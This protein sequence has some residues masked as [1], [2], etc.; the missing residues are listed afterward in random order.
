MRRY[1]SLAPLFALA[2][3]LAPAVVAAAPHSGP[4]A[5]CGP[6]DFGAPGWPACITGSAPSDSP[7]NVLPPGIFPGLDAPRAPV[8]PTSPTGPAP[9]RSNP[10]DQIPDLSTLPPG[11]TVDV[12]RGNAT[13]WGGSV[14]CTATNGNAPGCTSSGDL[15]CATPQPGT[16]ICQGGN[17]DG[18]DAAIPSP[19]TAAPPTAAPSPTMSMPMPTEAP[20]DLPSTTTTVPTDQPTAAPPASTS[21]PVGVSSDAQHMLDLYNSRRTAAG[22]QPVALNDALMRSAQGYADLLNSQR[23]S[24]PNNDPRWHTLAGTTAKQRIQQAGCPHPTTW[25]EN[26]AVGT[27]DQGFTFWYGEGPG[28]GHYENIM[29]PAYTQI[30]VGIAGRYIVVDHA[31]GCPTSTTAAPPL[32]ARPQPTRSMPMPS[33]TTAPAPIATTSSG[34]GAPEST[35]LLAAVNQERQ[36]A[37]LQP[38]ALADPLQASAQGYAQTMAANEPK[39]LASDTDATWHG[40]DGTQPDQRV[41]SA[42]CRWTS[43]GENV[44]GGYPTVAAVM[45]GWMSSPGHKAN[46]LNPDYRFVGFGHTHQQGGTMHDFWVQDFANQC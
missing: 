39:L 30:G 3:L 6:L 31:A 44:A 24:F 9:G 37:G 42:G 11:S 28:G 35:A 36:K 38:L 43:T 18:G 45:A 16:I 15:P 7:S 32:T 17:T 25:G 27:V 10:W 21:A 33:A 8:L 20:V 1:L 12:G 26:I 46:I 40:V 5:A 19:P 13:S 23:A 14:S 2:V 4:A 34:T 22:R 41:S 29:K